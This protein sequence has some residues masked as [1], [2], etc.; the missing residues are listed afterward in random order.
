MHSI[1]PVFG[2]ISHRPIHD[3]PAD[4]DNVEALVCVFRIPLAAVAAVAA[5]FIWPAVASIDLSAVAC[6][7]CVAAERRRT[8]FLAWTGMSQHCFLILGSVVKERGMRG[9]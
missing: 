7:D 8:L 5:A 2:L 3:G 4:D 6:A 1:F 9:T